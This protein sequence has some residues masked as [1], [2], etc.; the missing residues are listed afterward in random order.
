MQSVY[1]L[2]NCLEQVSSLIIIQSRFS[3]C[4]LATSGRKLRAQSRFRRQINDVRTSIQTRDV[5]V[6]PF[7]PCRTNVFPRV[8]A[9]RRIITALLR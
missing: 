3:S 1:F 6:A 2:F 5:H 4:Y 7:I 8:I 9:L